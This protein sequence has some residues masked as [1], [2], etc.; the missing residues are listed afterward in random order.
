MNAID[1]ASQDDKAA[2]LVELQHRVRNTLAAMRTLIRRSART[3]ESVDAYVM[4]LEGRLDAMARVQNAFV[5]NPTGGI[6]LGLLVADELAAVDARE[7]ERVRIDGPSVQLHPRAAEPFGLALHELATNALKFGALS[8]PS[9]RIAVT[10]R[11]EERDGGR[12][13]RFDWV[14]TGVPLGD[15]APAH[16]GFGR[17]VL[18]E[19][20]PH[21]LKARTTLAFTPQGLHGAID[22]PLTERVL[23]LVR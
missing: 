19:M 18:E 1:R 3:S 11:I 14:E 16:R 12:R 6:D 9:G 13:L 2:L 22:L 8:K 20:L 21:N 10:W 5:R 23:T 7:G 17:T 4:H 15:T